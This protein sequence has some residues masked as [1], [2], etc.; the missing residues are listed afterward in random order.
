MRRFSHGHGLLEESVSNT[1]SQDTLEG[2][3]NLHE[4]KDG[5]YEVVICNGRSHWETP[6]IIDD[7]DLKL[8]PFIPPQ[9][10]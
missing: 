8:V 5:L 1:S 4:C 3:I 7:Y 2:I 9:N 10:S 6:H